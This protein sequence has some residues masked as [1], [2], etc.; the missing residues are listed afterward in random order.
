MLRICGR[1]FR[2]I[3]RVVSE[4]KSTQQGK[5]WFWEKRVCWNS[6][7]LRIWTSKFVDIL[8]QKQEDAYILVKTWSFHV[9]DTRTTNRRTYTCSLRQERTERCVQIKSKNIYLECSDLYEIL[10]QYSWSVL[11]SKSVKKKN[12]FFKSELVVRPLKRLFTVQALW[13]TRVQLSHVQTEAIH[14]RA[15]A[16]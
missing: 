5:K 4:K 14:T 8:K 15:H 2:R 16:S 1:N 7:S 10:T 12:W 3:G 6:L 13:V 11:L 9:F